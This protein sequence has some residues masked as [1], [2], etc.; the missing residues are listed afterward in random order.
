MACPVVPVLVDDPGPKD[1][2]TDDYG[3]GRDPNGRSRW[4]WRPSG[5][6]KREDRGDLVRQWE[7][8]RG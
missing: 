3:L 1:G 7:R 2:G 4:R 8:A 5:A 6:V